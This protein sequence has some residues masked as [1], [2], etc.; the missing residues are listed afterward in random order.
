MAQHC[1]HCG[2]HWREK[3]NRAAF[4]IERQWRWG[5]RHRCPAITHHDQGKPRSLRIGQSE[6]SATDSL[7]M[8]DSTCACKSVAPGPLVSL[9][10]RHRRAKSMMSMGVHSPV[11]AWV[12]L[13]LKSQRYPCWW[14]NLMYIPRISS[15][16]QL[17][18]HDIIWYLYI[19]PCSSMIYLLVL[20][21]CYSYFIITHYKRVNLHKPHPQ[22]KPK[23]VCSRKQ[24]HDIL[25][26]GFNH[27]E[28]YESQLGWWHSQ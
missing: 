15:L 3:P 24:F 11:R 12:P 2:L 20:V 13:C 10:P 22:K 17:Y 4:P 19:G 5:A 14:L 1:F 18:L 6:R 16:I 8:H 23:S 21:I 9:R 25:V 28:K 7:A 26:G 27:L